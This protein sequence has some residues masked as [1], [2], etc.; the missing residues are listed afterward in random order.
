MSRMVAALTSRVSSRRLAGCGKTTI[1]VRLAG[2]DD[3][4]RHFGKDVHWVSLR[5]DTPTL[6]ADV[7][8]AQADLLKALRHSSTSPGG[9]PLQKMAEQWARNAGARG[10]CGAK[11]EPASRPTHA[12]AH[13]GHEPRSLYSSGPAGKRPRC[14][15]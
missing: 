3:L 14:R 7:E 6:A 1:A 11:A 10:L 12:C 9:A 5:A 4:R 8:R 15:G 2:D 13:P